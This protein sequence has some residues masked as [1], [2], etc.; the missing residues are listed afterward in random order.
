MKLGRGITGKVFWKGARSAA[1]QRTG[2][3]KRNP[4]AVEKIMT[5]SLVLDQFEGKARN[6]SI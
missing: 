1:L 4:D 5:T 6:G 2:S 3:N